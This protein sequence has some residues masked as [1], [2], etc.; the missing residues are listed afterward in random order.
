[1]SVL[2]GTLIGAGISALGGLLSSQA[3]NA[4]NA[5]LD[6]ETR[7]WQEKMWEK[8]NEYNTPVNQRRRL[9]AAGIN[10]ALA[11]ANG[12]TGVA[13]SA[14]SAVQHTPADYSALG[15]GLSQAG[16]MA[17]QAQNYEAN[18]ELLASQAEGNRIDNLTR[19]QKNI[20]E[21]D[22]LIADAKQK[23]ANTSFL[24][25]QKDQSMMLYDALY[26][27][28]YAEVENIRMDTELKSQMKRKEFALADYQEILNKYGVKNQEKILRNLDA[29]YM[30]ILSAAAN[31]NA[32]A[33]YAAAQKALT[34][35]NAETSK[36]VQ[37]YV[38][39][40]AFQEVEQIKDQREINWMRENR[41]ERGEGKR[42]PSA[43]GTYE[44][45]KS[46]YQT[47]QQNKRR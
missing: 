42:F 8:N 36:K 28:N 13:S 10:P 29:Q 15:S 18:N 45:S 34:D 37:K 1:M 46:Y 20:A 26:K 33:A 39:D 9:E 47:K 25:W 19:L 16:A 44:T 22:N 2:A 7:K 6:E 3:T 5:S 24:E 21:I 17:L 14:P 30:E 40:R 12:N 38:V 11:F 35:V 4:A 27:R 32:S 41:E 31:N 23:G 43:V